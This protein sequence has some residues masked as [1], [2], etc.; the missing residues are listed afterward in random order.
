MEP[1]GKKYGFHYSLVN[2][3]DWSSTN[4]ELFAALNFKS[5]IH[6]NFFFDLQKFDISIMP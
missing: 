5:L 2:K 4:F 3:Q 1:P 6:L